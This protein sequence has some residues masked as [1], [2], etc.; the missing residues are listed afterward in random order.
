MLQHVFWYCM[1]YQN[2][3]KKRDI[4]KGGKME[5]EKKYQIKYKNIMIRTI[6]GSTLDGKVNIAEANRVSDL[7]IG[8]KSKFIVMVDVSFK[9]GHGKTM[10]INKEHIVWVEPGS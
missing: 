5:E 6:D 1:N 4:K 3:I 2:V 7:F 10:F 9:D 8:G